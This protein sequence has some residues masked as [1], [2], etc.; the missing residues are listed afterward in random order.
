MVVV[1]GGG[2]DESGGRPVEGKRGKET[3]IKR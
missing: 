3:Y 1:A 2:G